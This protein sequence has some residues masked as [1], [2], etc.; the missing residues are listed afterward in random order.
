MNTEQDTLFQKGAGRTARLLAYGLLAI[1]M[2]AADHRG[3]YLGQF[4][5]WST[6]ALVPIYEAVGLPFAGLHHAGEYFQSQS[7]LQQQ[8]NRLQQQNLELRAQTLLVEKLRSDNQQLRELLGAQQSQNLNVVYV[9]LVRIGLDPYSHRVVINRGSRH[10]VRIAQAV[11]DAQGVFGQVESVSAGGA[12]VI[13]ISDPNHA[14]PVQINRTGMRTL[15]Y[16]SG[17]PNRL[18]LPDLPLNT[19][20][21]PGDIIATSGL[22]GH[23]HAGLPVAQVD[24]V[25]RSGQG[26][27]ISATATPLAGLD[28]SAQLVVITSPRSV[29]GFAQ[30]RPSQPL[31]GAAQQPSSQTTTGVAGEALNTSN[32]QPNTDQAASEPAVGDTDA[33]AN[34]GNT[35]NSGEGAQ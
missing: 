32:N 23:F 34:E 3:H 13:L 31:Q 17:N 20:I 35:E 1:M 7:N 14:L 4:R 16:G 25:D 8:L 28:R 26:D 15:A 18:V 6:H 21:R 9:E 12:E 27:F 11:M 33:S 2:M 30:P 5:Q 29:D 22:G 10:G 19:D 24:A